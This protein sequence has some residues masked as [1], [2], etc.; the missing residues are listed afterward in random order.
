[1]MAKEFY[2]D[3][4]KYIPMAMEM[5]NAVAKDVA[6]AGFKH[7]ILFMPGFGNVEHGKIKPVGAQITT[8]EIIKKIG[9]NKKMGS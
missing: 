5:F 7:F 4:K 6:E 9:R 3:K 1:M 8:D 2:F